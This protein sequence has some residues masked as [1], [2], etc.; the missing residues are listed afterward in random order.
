MLKKVSII[1]LIL[2]SANNFSECFLFL[3]ENYIAYRVLN[4]HKKQHIYAKWWKRLAKGIYALQKMKIFFQ[5]LP[6]KRRKL[7]FL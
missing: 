7:L 4:Q 1:M 3:F 6:V 5:S 2:K